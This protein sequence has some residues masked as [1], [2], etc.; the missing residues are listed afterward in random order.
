MQG[1]GR[2]G[3]SGGKWER[4]EEVKEKRSSAGLSGDEK[5]RQWMGGGGGEED[6]T[7]IS[8]QYTAAAPLLLIN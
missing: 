6:S 3:G 5:I 7:C 1:R 2:K 8:F 4:K